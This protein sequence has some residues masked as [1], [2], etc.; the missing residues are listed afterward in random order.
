MHHPEVL[1]RRG[2]NLATRAAR[3]LGRPHRQTRTVRNH[4]PQPGDIGIIQSANPE[5][6]LTLSRIIKAPRS[7]VWNAWTDRASFEQ[8]WV[9]APAKCRVVEMHLRP[10]GAII[11]QISATGDE[12]GSPESGCFL[13]IDELVRIAFTDSL[14]GGWRPAEQS[15]MTAVITL[16]DHP[17]GTDYVAYVMHKNDADRKMHEKMGFHAEWGQG[18]GAT[19]TTRRATYLTKE[20]A[21]T[22]ILPS[23]GDH[24]QGPSRNS[25]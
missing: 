3:P 24:A 18:V 23:A 25:K 8:W 2:G 13:A 19:R 6:D 5:L 10:G 20:T 15:F 14:V 11:T 7:A 12:F 4:Q 9:P 17:L 1:V 21:D 22:R 16:T